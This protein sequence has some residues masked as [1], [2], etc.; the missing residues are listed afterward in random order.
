MAHVLA[1]SGRRREAEAIVAEL[2]ARARERYVTPVAFCIAHLGLRNVDQVFHWLDRAYE[3][4]RGWLT[5]MKVDPIFE[6][7]RADRRFPALLDRLGL[8]R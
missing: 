6:T 2:D 5:Y 4:R 3:D 7:V 8:P 1:L